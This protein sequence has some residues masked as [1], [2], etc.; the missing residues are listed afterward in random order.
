[1]SDVNAALGGPDSLTR[2]IDTTL[3]AVITAFALWTIAYHVAMVVHAP[4]VVTTVAWVAGVVVLGVL[5]AVTLPRSRS[6]A[7]NAGARDVSDEVDVEPVRSLAVPAGVVAAVAA[8]FAG[9]RVLSGR[10]WWLFELMVAAALVVAAVAVL[11]GRVVS[12]ASAKRFAL[13]PVVAIA[14][15]AA[16]AAGSLFIVR[17]DA[18]D[19]L[20]VNRSVWIEH[21]G[22]TFPQRDTL[23]SNQQFAYTRPE[24]PSPAIEPFVGVIARYTPWSAPSV[25]Y[26]GVGSAVSFLAVLAL[27]R[28]LR[29]L[30]AK[31]AWLA[32]VVSAAFLAFDG[33]IHT[34]FG[35]FSFVRAWQGKVIFVFLIVPLLWRHALAWSRHGERRALVLLVA[36]NVAAVGVSTTA[37]F[38]APPVTVLGV[39][40]GLRREQLR[41]RLTGTV[42]ALLYPLGGG[43]FAATAARQPVAVALAAGAGNFVAAV[44]HPA[45]VPAS[46]L[47]SW[48]PWY[49][50]IGTGVMGVVAAVA[51]LCGWLGT[52]ERSSRIALVLAP[53]ALLGV[54]V[55]P[56][57]LHALKSASSEGGSVLWRVVWIVPV[58]AMVG[59]LATGLLARFG[60]RAVIASAAAVIVVCVAGGTPVWARRNGAFVVS[61]PQWDITPRDEKAASRLLTLAAPG[62]VVAAPESIGGAIAIRSADV[63]AVDPRGQYLVGR[64]SHA[65]SFHP[66]ERRL[67]TI[68]VTS[69]LTPA[70]AAAF[71]ASLQ[72]LS[73]DV[74]CTR[75]GLE[76]GLVGAALTQA[77][78]TDVRHDRQCH[79]WQRT[80]R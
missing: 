48:T 65:P 27:W 23:F 29:E 61:H 44:G 59:L 9:S 37:L 36:S 28:L 77:G 52:R 1:M 56:P 5:A 40:A 73:V 72:L 33:T 11:R 30:R 38:V 35:N 16:F 19:V 66:N 74:A 34:S 7:H 57:V 51:T 78:F 41:G 79:Y 4:V 53:L 21:H 60:T 62:D 10:R 50:V 68:G 47:H 80:R 75:P 24:N 43:L 70:N 67:V 45:P 8:I 42:V 18:D 14:V 22:N 15:A 64:V 17:S 25:A 6:G 49:F 46:P 63:R 13:A 55:T 54:F 69:G 76:H 12:G 26:L 3:D 20:T 2:G 71:A 32:L 31:F 39:L 58:P